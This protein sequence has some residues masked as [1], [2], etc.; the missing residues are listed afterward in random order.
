MQRYPLL[1]EKKLQSIAEN[2]TNSRQTDQL[3]KYT[4]A[5]NNVK[6]IKTF[7]YIEYIYKY[8]IKHNN[9]HNYYVCINNINY[10]FSDIQYSN[11][12]SSICVTIIYEYFLNNRKN[13]SQFLNNM[14]NTLY[15][16]KKIIKVSQILGEYK[17]N[18][19]LIEHIKKGNISLTIFKKIISYA[20]LEYLYIC[21]NLLKKKFNST[22]IKGTQKE[23]L[24]NH[25]FIK[26][27]GLCQFTEY[28]H[29]RGIRR[30]LQLNQ[31]NISINN[32]IYKILI[33]YFHIDEL[34]NIAKALIPLKKTSILTQSKVWDNDCHVKRRKHINY[35]RA[36]RRR[37][38]KAKAKA[39]VI[40]KAKSKAIAIRTIILNIITIAI[41][42]ICLTK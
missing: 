39:K 20:P 19:L 25:Y 28:R 17:M 27:N 24:P 18:L 10:Y 23:A 2:A 34:D 37:K 12:I 32:S 21:N 3:D 8:S 9:E 14:K 42:N 22:F 4:Y 35:L 31:I 7:I 29:F 13:K 36:Q 1:D 33:L 38:A 5:Y 26:I 15:N 30:L 11:F 6:L 40:A 16:F 41:S